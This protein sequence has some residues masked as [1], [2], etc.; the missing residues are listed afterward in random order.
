MG[1]IVLNKERLDKLQEIIERQLDAM[2]LAHF[3][4]EEV[5]KTISRII[6]SQFKRYL[7]IY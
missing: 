2:K 6:I 3:E 5:R 4:H 7:K 1:K